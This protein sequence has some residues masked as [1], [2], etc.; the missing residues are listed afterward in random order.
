CGGFEMG[1]SQAAATALCYNLLLPVFDKFKKYFL[2]F[3]I[4][5]YGSQWHFNIHIGAVG[6]CAGLFAAVLAVLG[7]KMSFEFKMVKR[8]KVFVGFNDYVPAA[9]A[10]AAVGTA[11][12]NVFFPPH[13]LAAL[14]SLAGSDVNLYVIYKIAFSHFFF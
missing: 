2:G 5:D 9:T 10:I 1:I 3:L 4:A 13:V 14:P 12:G 6:T 7:L 8:P 11:F